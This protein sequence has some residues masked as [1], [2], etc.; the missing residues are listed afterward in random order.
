MASRIHFKYWKNILISELYE[1]F[2]R[3]AARR[4]RNASRKISDFKNMNIL[5]IALKHV[6]WRFR[7]CNCFCEISKFRDFMNTLTLL[8][9]AFYDFLSYEEGIF[10]PHPRKQC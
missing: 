8:P 10:I 1:Q 4:L 5:Y 6:I 9:T 7:I 3:N 2:S